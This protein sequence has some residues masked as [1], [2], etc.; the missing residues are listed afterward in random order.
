[1]LQQ[2]FDFCRAATSPGCRVPGEPPAWAGAD[3]VGW[4]PC[5][6]GPCPGGSGPGEPSWGVPGGGGHR[7]TWAGATVID[8][9]TSRFF[10]N[11]ARKNGNECG[12]L[13]L[14]AVPS[15]ESRTEE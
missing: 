15:Q 12:P 5:F 2:A 4:E 11:L 6:G 8:I 1:M 3:K 9:R 7:V 10:G 13:L 14:K